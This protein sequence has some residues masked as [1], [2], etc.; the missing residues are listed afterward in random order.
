MAFPAGCRDR[1]SGCRIF[2]G[3]LVE[4]LCV[5]YF[6]PGLD[7]CSGFSVAATSGFSHCD[8]ADMAGGAFTADACFAK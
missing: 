2:Y 4:W 7:L 3:K 6:H 8:K 1:D 5:S